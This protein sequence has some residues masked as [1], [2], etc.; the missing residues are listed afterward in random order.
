MPDILKVI[1]ARLIGAAVA[2]VATW[3]FAKYGILIP[4]EQ[5][6]QLTE[7]IVAAMMTIFTV[8][9]A[10]VHK[11]ASVKLNPADAATPTLAKHGEAEQARL[12]Q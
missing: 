3:L 6:A 4:D 9:Y 2:G 8:V 10:V 5:K 12:K 1:L 7:A 11:L